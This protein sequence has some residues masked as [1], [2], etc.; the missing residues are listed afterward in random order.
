[1]CWLPLQSAVPPFAPAVVEYEKGKTVTFTLQVCVQRSS[2]H[3]DC[4]SS[5]RACEP[6]LDP[7]APAE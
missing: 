7:H 2:A 1:M 5:G 3:P 4:L 6:G